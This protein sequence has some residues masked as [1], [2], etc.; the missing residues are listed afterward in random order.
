MYYLLLKKRA[1][2]KSAKTLLEEIRSNFTLNKFQGLVTYLY[3]GSRS[4]LREFAE[5]KGHIDLFVL[6]SCTQARIDFKCHQENDFQIINNVLRGILGFTDV[7][8]NIVT[9]LDKSLITVINSLSDDTVDEVL[10]ILIMFLFE[11]EDD[12]HRFAMAKR[13]LKYFRNLEKNGQNGWNI[14]ASFIKGK[15][16][17]SQTKMKIVVSFFN[18]LLLIFSKNS[19]LFMEW[20]KDVEKSGIFE[21]MRSNGEFFEKTIQSI[22]EQKQLHVHGINVK[23]MST[24]SVDNSGEH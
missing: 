17:Q 10:K 23:I 21:A 20:F 8:V 7:Y 4:F 14:V 3:C 9:S 5:N 2:S 13:I 22:E 12:D 1:H 16:I 24:L 19:S 6:L 11:H 18:A 15:N